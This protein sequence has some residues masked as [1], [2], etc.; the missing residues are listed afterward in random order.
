[1]PALANAIRDALSPLGPVEVGMPAT[2]HRIWRA[3]RQ[4]RLARSIP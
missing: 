4:A 1:L 3:M 2:P